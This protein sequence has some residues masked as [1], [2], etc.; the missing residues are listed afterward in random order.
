[1]IVTR[2]RY[3]A[4]C[5]MAASSG[6]CVTLMVGDGGGPP[7]I[8]VIVLGGRLASNQHT[9]EGA[10]YLGLSDPCWTIGHTHYIAC[11]HITSNGNAAFP[12]HLTLNALHNHPPKPKTSFFS[13]PIF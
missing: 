2:W 10:H 13:L 7:L 11:H 3:D 8:A 9:H 5:V 4:W 6:V 12:S 1:M